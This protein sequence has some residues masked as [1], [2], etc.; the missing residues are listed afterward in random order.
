MG[1]Q[2]SIQIFLRDKNSRKSSA[3]ILS[4]SDKFLYIAK[5][6]KSSHDL[7]VGRLQQETYKS[8]KCPPKRGYISMGG[9][10][11]RK[12]YVKVPEGKYIPLFHSSVAMYSGELM[13]YTYV[14]DRLRITTCVESTSVIT[15]PNRNERSNH[16]VWS[17]LRYLI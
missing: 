7:V 9:S 1:E 10:S 2:D 4:L 14:D 12:L 8:L 13:V 5:L 11:I 17:Q 16:D 15:G 3:T 6:P